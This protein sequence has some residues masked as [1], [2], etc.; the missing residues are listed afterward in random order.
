MVS[1]WTRA[2]KD[3]YKIGIRKGEQ[4]QLAADIN[5][6]K[7]AGMHSAARLLAG[8]L[9]LDTDVWIIEDLD[10]KGRVILTSKARI[11]KA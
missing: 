10:A 2:E 8:E 9:P 7:A 1:N 11:T 6:L 4:N 3:A 5:T